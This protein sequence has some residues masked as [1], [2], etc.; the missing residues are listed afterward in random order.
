MIVCHCFK[1]ACGHVCCFLHLLWYFRFAFLI[2]FRL[3]V[4]TF[5]PVATIMHLL[6]I[7][8]HGLVVSRRF[9]GILC[10]FVVTFWHLLHHW[11][12]FGPFPDCLKTLSHYF[13]SL[14]VSFASFLAGCGLSLI[15][16]HQGILTVTLHRCP[17][18]PTS[19][20]PTLV[21]GSLEIQIF[22]PPPATSSCPSSAPNTD[23]QTHFCRAT[24]DRLVNYMESCSNGER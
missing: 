13:S 15:K 21:W 3:I 6:L 10:L 18:I 2:V 7:I 17:L 4:V 9:I 22:P 12:V 8:F 23:P 20:L 19:S 11:L 1:P 5:H 16:M 14:S 24:T